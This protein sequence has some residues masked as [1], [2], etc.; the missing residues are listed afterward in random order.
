MKRRIGESVRKAAAHYSASRCIQ[1]NVW[2]VAILLALLTG[3]LLLGG[4]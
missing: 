2:R 3:V 4:N 1:D